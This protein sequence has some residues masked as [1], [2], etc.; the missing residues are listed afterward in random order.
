MAVSRGGSRINQKLGDII[1]QEGDLLVM[2]A[3]EVGVPAH[4]SIHSIV[5]IALL[6]VLSHN[7]DC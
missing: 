7:H 1:L 3:A 5:N 6:D 2:D 4:H